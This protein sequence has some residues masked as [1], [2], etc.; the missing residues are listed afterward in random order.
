MGTKIALFRGRGIR[1]TLHNNEWWF[2]IADAVG[3]LTDSADPS[4]YIKDMRRRDK[5]LSK[6]WGQ[7]ATPLWIET[8]GGKQKINCANTEGIFR[9]IQ[10]IPSPKAEPFKRWLAK[11]GYERVQEIEDPELGT[12]RTRALYKVKGYSDAWIEKRM[13]GITIREELTDEWK[14]RDVKEE[15][16]YAI[17]TA[18]IA[19]AAFGVTPGEHKQ[20][21]GLKRENLRDHM[22]D[23]ELIFSMLGEA[24]TTEITRVDD[25]QGFHKSKT[26]ARKGG[27]VAGKLP[28]RAGKQETAESVREIKRPSHGK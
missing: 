17:L 6:G 5:E 15:R 23:L 12:K 19:Q 11:V 13:R 3:V 21:K 4:G 2:V 14:N 16:E 27:G 8:E 28:E 25:A 1:K 22:T 20:L 7:I 26:A 24:A 18:E 10:S 9:I